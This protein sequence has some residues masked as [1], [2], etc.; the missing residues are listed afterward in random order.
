MCKELLQDIVQ[1][2]ITP[3][4]LSLE[5][6]FE[7]LS[8]VYQSIPETNQIYR[9]KIKQEFEIIGFMYYFALQQ[10][11]P[12]DIS[13]EEA[14]QFRSALGQVEIQETNNHRFM[15][16]LNIEGTKNFATFDVQ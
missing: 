8:S 13:F 2:Q 5:G 7:I 4:G 11:N 12:Q 9:E 1:L 14:D 6:Y 16:S 15:E 10:I 3:R